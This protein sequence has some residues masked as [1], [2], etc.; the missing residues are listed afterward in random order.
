MGVVNTKKRLF[1]ISSTFTMAIAAAL[2]KQLGTENT[3][4]YVVSISPFIY[5]NVDEHIKMEYQYLGLFKDIKFYFDF[6]APKKNFKEEMSHILSFNV[7]KFKESIGNVEFDEIYSVYIHGAANHLFNQY[8]KA[9]LYFMEDGTAAY[10]K[11]DNAEQINKRA[12][13]IYT[14]NYFDKIIP[15]ISMYENVP[16]V[17]IDKNILKEIFEQLSKNIKFNLEIKE[18]SVVFCAQNISISQIAMTYQD[19]LNLYVKYIKKLLN[20]GYFVYFKDHPKTPN[21]FY[22]NIVPIINNPNFATVGAYSV[23]PLESL[24]ILLKPSAIVSMFSSALFSIPW[25]YNIPAFTFFADKEFKAHK[26]FGIA[27]MLVATYIPSIEFL[28]EDVQIARNN[29]DLFLSKTM[30]LNQQVY[31]RVKLIDFFKLFISHK[32]YRLLQKNLKTSNRLILRF[33]NINTD[34]LEM[35]KK[36]SYLS[37]LKYYSGDFCKRCEAYKQNKIKK[38]KHSKKVLFEVFDDAIT[39]LLKLIF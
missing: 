20:M 35:F 7:K 3:D 34:V 26:I 36:Q 25:L 16:T 8:P 29:F 24:V 32:E 5:E 22:K 10:L 2:V 38:Y 9:D 1:I 28:N 27:H 37:Y 6:C 4:N 11:M 15:Y 14:L 21:M 12:K 19:E 33:F 31:Y 23:L 17:Q 18:K 30:H 13:K 39:I